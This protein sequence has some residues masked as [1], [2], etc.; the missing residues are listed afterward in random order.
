M[1][2]DN[3]IQGDNSDV[4]SVLAEHLTIQLATRC[5]ENMCFITYPVSEDR[6]SIVEL[7]GGVGTL[8]CVKFVD[9]EVQGEDEKTMR[10]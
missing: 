5:D 7:T 9:D 3:G 1:K 4:V 10:S 6:S 8:R 2:G